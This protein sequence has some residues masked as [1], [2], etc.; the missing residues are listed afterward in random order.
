VVNPTP[1]IFGFT[2]NN[3]HTI[4]LHRKIYNHKVLTYS[5]SLRFEVVY[6]GLQILDH[7]NIDNFFINFFSIVNPKLKMLSIPIT[8]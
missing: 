5:M 3:S 1:K 7:N 6:Y 2:D 8:N 4:H